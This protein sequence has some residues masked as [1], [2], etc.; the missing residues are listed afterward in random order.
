MKK[1]RC[2]VCN[3]V[4]DPAAGDPDCGVEPGTPF[5]SFGRLVLPALRR[6][7]DEFEI[8]EE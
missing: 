4:Y 3:Y 1:W 8:V 7:Q 6:G 2:L 5:E